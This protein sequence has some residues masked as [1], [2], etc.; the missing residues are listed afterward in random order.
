MIAGDLY[1]DVELWPLLWDQ[2]KAL[3]PN[4]NR[5]KPGMVLQ[6]KELSEFTPAQIADAK[7]RSPTWKDYPHP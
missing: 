2:N 7:R 3:I 1:H 6:Y 4:P 5:I